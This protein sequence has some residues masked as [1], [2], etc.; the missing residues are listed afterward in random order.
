MF[1]KSAPNNSFYETFVSVNSQH[2]HFGLYTE[3]SDSRAVAL[4]N[5][6]DHLI[7]QARR[8][9]GNISKDSSV[10]VAS[11]GRLG[12]A[13]HVAKQT[14]A[15]VTA[16]CAND[17]NGDESNYVMRK[18]IN[19]V[20]PNSTDEMFA[21][22]EGS[23]DVVMIVEGL[24]TAHDKKRVLEDSHRILKTGGLLVVLDVI[25][26]PGAHQKDLAPFEKEMG[27][28]PLLTLF[29]YEQLLNEAGLVVMRTSDLSA[30]VVKSYNQVIEN[31]RKS[32]IQTMTCAP[33]LKNSILD[34]LE[35]DVKNM[36]SRD[37]I[38]W[39]SFVALKE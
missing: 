39:T 32:D 14:S 25:A 16:V 21:H 11:G 1:R 7:L 13:L 10:L 12:P 17:H 26:R 34:K 22:D 9:G 38:G 33:D 18:E 6:I 15:H 31:A 37:T 20:Q 36:H 28:P 24:T 3:K 5:A 35:N 23:F 4:S 30:H 19:V 8:T 29:M 27:V 2:D